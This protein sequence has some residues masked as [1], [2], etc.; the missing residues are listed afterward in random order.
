MEKLNPSRSRNYWQQVKSLLFNTHFIPNIMNQYELLQLLRHNAKQAAVQLPKS[1]N[2]FLEKT[3]LI[4]DIPTKRTLENMQTD[5][6]AIESWIFLLKRW[7][8]KIEKVIIKWESL[9]PDYIST[10]ENA[11]YHYQRFLYRMDKTSKAF[12]WVTIPPSNQLD[13]ATSTF[14]TSKNLL[15]N[16]PSTKRATK[17]VVKKELEAYTESELE[18]LILFDPQ[19]SNAFKQHFNLKTIDYQLPVGI[20]EAN[21]SN[22]TRVFSG[23]K[24]AIDIWGIDQDDNCCLFE[25]KKAQNRKVGVLSE[26]FFY[27]HILLDVLNKNIQFAQTNQYIQPILNAKKVKCFLLAPNSH[28]LIDKTVFQLMNTSQFGIQY[29]QAFIQEADSQS[30]L[31][32]DFSAK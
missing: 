26:M 13:L 11:I 3:T 7:I 5:G 19:T 23:R 28:P 4:I 17:T 8:P 22:S 1:L 18:A 2:I 10:K 12:P 32:S 9:P 15:M 24:S 14:K 30:I 25:L 31:F 29:A 16:T 20:F 27:A 21:I 6:A